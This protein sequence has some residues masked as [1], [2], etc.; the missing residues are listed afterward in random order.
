M[1]TYLVEVKPGRKVK[2]MQ[3]NVREGG[4]QFEYTPH[5]KGPLQS[6]SL[7]AIETLVEDGAVPTPAAAPVAEV[8]DIPAAPTG[9]GHPAAN[10]APVIVQT[11][12]GTEIVGSFDPTAALSPEAIKAHINQVENAPE[13]KIVKEELAPAGDRFVIEKKS[14]IWQNVVDTQTGEV[15]NEKGMKIEDAEDFKQKLID[16]L[17]SK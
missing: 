16:A 14:G 3:G 10:A 17:V 6:L 11:G 5:Y 1:A 7:I 8:P 4:E 15:M 2:D 12:E 9:E 13:V